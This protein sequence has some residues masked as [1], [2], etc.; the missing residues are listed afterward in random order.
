MPTPIPQ[1]TL[2]EKDV[3]KRQETT[4]EDRW[5]DPTGE[6]PRKLK[7]RSAT[8]INVFKWSGEFPQPDEDQLPH[9]ALGAVHVFF[10]TRWLMEF[11]STT[12]L[13]LHRKKVYRHISGLPAK[14]RLPAFHDPRW[15]TDAFASQWRT[16]HA[17]LLTTIDASRKIV[18]LRDNWDGDGATGY[19]YE[20][21]K[22]ATD[23]LRSLMRLVLSETDAVHQVPRI[24]PADQGS[25]DLFWKSAERELLIN[26][27]ADADALASYYGQDRYG[28][29]TSGLI[30]TGSKPV[31]LAGWLTQG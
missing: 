18:R 24:N 4:A 23:F 27:P 17:T 9:K 12:L 13:T 28:N 11:F 26:V 20:T 19:S 7:V 1:F 6:S 5:F 15:A 31:A 29:T 10:L 25:I 16:C 22:R 30:H 3:W 14:R 8:S 2:L 21:W